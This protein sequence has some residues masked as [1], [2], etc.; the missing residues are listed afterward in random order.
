MHDILSLIDT[1]CH[2]NLFTTKEFDAPLPHNFKEE[3]QP[4]VCAAADKQVT[5]IINVG[6]NVQESLN[7]IAIAH[8]FSDCFA[9]VGIH[10]TDTNSMHEND[11]Q[12]I[13]NMLDNKVD[14]TIVAIGEV[15]LDY[16]H[17]H[18][19]KKQYRIFEQHILLALE[20]ALPLIIHTRSAHDEALTILR[21]FACPELR[22]VIHCFSEDESFAHKALDIKFKLGIG[23]P[24]TYPKNDRLRDI[25]SSVDLEH[26]V[27]ET[28][29]PF[30]APQSIRGKQNSPAEINTIAHYLAD[31]RHVSF[32][33]IAQQ[34][35]CNA[36]ELFKI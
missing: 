34:T 21:N 19:K 11:M 4:F 17:E 31:I 14:S 35:T 6:T 10:P 33:E 26:I 8:A 30:L 28:D 9:A 23:G 7:C 13:K 29:A 3:I 24:L 20:Y 5:K 12:K 16:Y 2:L 27:L 36:Q 25:F 15:G 32:E 18:D 22:G 1:H